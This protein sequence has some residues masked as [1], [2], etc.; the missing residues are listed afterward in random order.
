MKEFD[1]TGFLNINKEAGFTSHDVVAK[2]RGILHTKKIGHTGTLDP[3]ATG[4]LPV[5]IG[6]AAKTIEL[7]TDHSKAYDAV[8]LLGTVTDTYDITGAVLSTH[9]VTVSEAQVRKVC[10]SFVGEI[11][12]IP[13]MY[14]AKK[15]NGKKLYELAREGRQI[16]RA[17][18]RVQIMSLDITGI[19][20]PYV[21]FSVECSKGTYIRCL[22]YSIGEALG[23]GGCLQSLR[24][25]RAGS[26]LLDNA[27][28][29]SE[30]EQARDDGK[31]E[32]LLLPTDAA[33]AEYPKVTVSERFTAQALNGS[34]IPQQ[35]TAS[36]GEHAALYRLYLSDGRFLGLYTYADGCYRVR[37][38]CLLN[39]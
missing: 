15:V 16:E 39:G 14:S 30:V 22:C 34:Q 36:E 6:R 28:R 13:P 8:M 37:K 12:Q 5:A 18:Q 4:V 27:Y 32:A 11:S 21:S 10:A 29:L 17:P 1:K 35:K 33:F 19:A 20:L 25:T 38:L 2:L 3:M 31:L 9:D 24:R 7:L 23:C 26:F